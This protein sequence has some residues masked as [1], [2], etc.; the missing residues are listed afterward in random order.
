MRQTPEA[1]ARERLA[2]VPGPWRERVRRQHVA[3]LAI[4][5]AFP[6]VTPEWSAA[7][8]DANAWLRDT[9]TRFEG[10]RVP[11]GLSDDE[12]IALAEKNAR[13]MF[14]RCT[15]AGRD[16][17][18]VRADMAAE[19][20]A[21]GIAPPAEDVEDG[22]A[23][24]RMVDPLW[25]RRKLRQSQARQ[26][27]GHAIGLGY[28]HRHGEIYA[29]N[30]TVA[31]R[32][33]QRARNQAGLEAT[34]AINRQTGE[35]YTLAE[36]AEKSVANPRIRRGELMTRIAG[37]E[38]VA[39]SL[40]QAAEF[41][42]LTTPSKYHPKRIGEGGKVEDNPKYEGATPRDAQGYLT[43]LWA[44]LRA[45]LWRRGIR[46]Y[47]F[48]IAEPHHDG[49]P[50]WHLLL[51]LSPAMSIGR[52]AVGRMRAMFRRYALREDGGE[53]GAKKKRVE[54]VAI[55]WGR[56]SAAGYVAKYVSKNIDDGGGYEV[57][58]DIEG[59]DAIMPTH[60]VEA[61]ASTWGIRQFQQIGGPPVGVWRELRRTEETPELSEKIEAARS[62]A[63]VGNWRRFVEVM[64]GPTVK[65][66]ELPLRVAYTRKGERYDYAAA[67][68]YP[69]LNRYGEP[70][71]PAVWGVEDMAKGRAY[72]SLRYSW[73]I[74]HGAGKNEVRNNGRELCLGVDDLIRRRGRG[75]QDG[76]LAAHEGI[77]GRGEADNGA[78]HHLSEKA[79]GESL[80][81]TAPESSPTRSPVNNCS[82]SE[83]ANGKTQPG[84]ACFC[85]QSENFQGAPPPGGPLLA[86][87]IDRGPGNDR[88]HAPPYRGIH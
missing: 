87:G 5:A 84:G 62:A 37:F 12:L 33:Q 40:G 65:R 58:G 7:V 45:A 39:K 54:F 63:D 30:A 85:R 80:A 32:Q 44:N 64:G 35:V 41:I 15:Y 10:L 26:L 53:P 71:A 73:E 47:G 27:E 82:R 72:A 11:V 67:I 20:R 88:G 29:S 46:P 2:L 74:K 21:W 3:R 38:A 8:R 23:I 50:H 66:R 59:L 60:R 77:G 49:T 81:G 43:R 83:H 14:D 24:A 48:R 6:E 42:T 75:H 86:V 78:G 31:R 16:A 4:A 57:Q 22:P 68:E 17:A 79:Y 55:D 52:S 1:W 18:E 34:E 28:V 9:S 76:P 13:A 36:L 25:W 56:G 19:V 69:A 70:A 51:F 61:W